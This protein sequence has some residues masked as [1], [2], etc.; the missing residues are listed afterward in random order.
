[1]FSRYW[2]RGRRR[3][4]GRRAEDSREIY[5]DRYTGTEWA[6]VLWVLA[7]SLLDL[8]LTLLHLRSGGG[9]ANPIMDAFLTRG[10]EAGFI[11]AKLA[12]TAVPLLFLLLH[13]RFR[14]T[15]VALI[16]LGGIYLALMAYHGVAAWDRMA[17]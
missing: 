10:G 17:R 8:G 2:L 13:V 16:G 6:L 4:A 5:V 1:M 3:S 15:K 7:A 11:V 14:P 9:E 12:M